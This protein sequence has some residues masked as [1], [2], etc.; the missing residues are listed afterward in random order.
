[1]H[2]VASRSLKVFTTTLTAGLLALGTPVLAAAA[3]P[4]GAQCAN[5]QAPPPAVDTSERP[6]PGRAAP[7]ALPVPSVPVG[8][9]R[10]AECG[11]VTPDGALNPPDGN[12][13]ASWVLQDLDTGAIIAAKDPHARQRLLRR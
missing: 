2:S 13:A 12:T 11:L 9:P 4:Q 5:H 7:A 8:G 6:A 10:L 3:P 1:M